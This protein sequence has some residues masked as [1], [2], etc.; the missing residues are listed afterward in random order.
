[1]TRIWL[2]SD[3]HFGHENIYKFV[4]FD[5]VTRV[6]Q[7]F[8]SAKDA[9][10][11]MLDRWNDLVR[12][13]DHIYHLGDVAMNFSPWVETIK[14][15]PGHKRLILGNH[16]KGRPRQYIDAGFEKIMGSRYWDRKVAILSH[17]PLHPDSL[18]FGSALNIHGHIHD[19]KLSDP[20]Y[21]NVCVEHTDYEPILLEQVLTASKDRGIMGFSSS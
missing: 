6:R 10:S 1:M 2:I 17:I 7:R 14:K 15:L 8:D 9:D 21:V 19:R 16:D 11:F 5:G 18:G 12:P 13:E 4:S 20:R 3:T